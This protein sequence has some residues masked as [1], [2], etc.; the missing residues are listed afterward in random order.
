MFWKVE[1]KLSLSLTRQMILL[2]SLTTIFI[3]AL[4]CV[5]LFPSF[6]K[7]THIDNLTYQH[8]LLGQCIVK[9][10]IVLLFSVVSAIIFSSLITKRIMNKVHHLSSRIKNTTVNSLTNKINADDLP[11]E[12]KPLAE[13]YNMMLDQLQHSFNQISQFS[14]DIAHEIRNP[15]NNLLGIN[16]VAL[17]NQY[18]LEKHHEICESNVEECRYL[19]KIIENLWFIARSE[20]GQFSINKSLLN[21]KEEILNIIDYYE[22]YASLREIE[23]SCEGEAKFLADDVLFKRAISN[24]LSN[25]LNYTENKGKITIKISSTESWITLFIADTGIGI[26]EEHLPKLFDRFYRVDTSRSSQT[27]GLGLGLSIVKSIMNLHQGHI[28]IQSKINLG[29]QVYLNFPVI[30]T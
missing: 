21:A 11:I 19:L 30:H 23:I 18:T 10:I 17:T 5:I 29:T 27:G 15:L 20:N 2:C 24:I 28:N 16:E 13:S 12:L 1:N 4:V 7:I 26:G 3:V 8:H 14:S 25:A 9:L 22:A 6:E